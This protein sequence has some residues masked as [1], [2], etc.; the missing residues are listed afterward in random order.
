MDSHRLAIHMAEE[1]H[2]PFYSGGT[3]EELRKLPASKIQESLEKGKPRLF[4]LSLPP[5]SE[6]GLIMIP[7]GVEP[8]MMPNHGYL[9]DLTQ[10]QANPP[11]VL[12]VS[13]RNL[14]SQGNPDHKSFNFEDLGPPTKSPL[15][16]ADELGAFYRSIANFWEELVRRD[17]NKQRRYDQE[18]AWRDDIIRAMAGP[19]AAVYSGKQMDMLGQYYQHEPEHL[20]RFNPD[21]EKNTVS[22][23]E[24]LVACSTEHIAAIT[25]PLYYSPRDDFSLQF[26]RSQAKLQAAIAG[27]EH[28]EHQIDLPVVI[29]DMHAP[30]ESRLHYVGRGREELLQVGREAIKEISREDMELLESLNRRDYYK[31]HTAAEKYFGVDLRVGVDVSS[32]HWEL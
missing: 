22:H 26:L 32:K 9:F 5:S 27:L 2:E 31:L 1:M 30:A 13:H 14:A 28:L 29:Y 24:M 8:S 12:R 4:S 18:E 16:F 3:Q 23:N 7:Y 21:W 19:N 15:C 17:A 20:T 11:R 10:D 6:S 25:I